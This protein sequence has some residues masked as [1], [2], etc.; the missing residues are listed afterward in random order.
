MIDKD[1]CDKGFIWNPSN[2]ECDKSCGVGEYL[3]YL[4]CKCRQKFVDKFVE[5]CSENIDEVE[6]EKITLAENENEYENVCK[7]SCTLYIMLLST[8]F[9]I[10]IGISTS[11]I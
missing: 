11:F 7:C 10:N 9:T 2:C 3:D 5:E 8:I 4:N 6:M 1:S